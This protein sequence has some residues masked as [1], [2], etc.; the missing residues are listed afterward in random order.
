[1]EPRHA[2]ATRPASRPP[3]PHPFPFTPPRSQAGFRRI[4]TRCRVRAV[5]RSTAFALIT[6]GLF[7]TLASAQTPTP[8]QP[9][10]RITPDDKVVRRGEVATFTV[11]VVNAS[12]IDLLRTG[13]S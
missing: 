3:C 2:S 5:L 7:S 6:L 1:M 4:A 11:E 9:P 12:G 10:I 13:A 8:E